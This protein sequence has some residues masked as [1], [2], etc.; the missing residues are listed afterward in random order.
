MADVTPLEIDIL[1]IFYIFADQFGKV[2]I[3]AANAWAKERF[4]ITLEDVPFKFG[5]QHLNMLM[6]SEILYDIRPLLNNIK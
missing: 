5:Q 6:D 1:L 2:D 3:I 4:G